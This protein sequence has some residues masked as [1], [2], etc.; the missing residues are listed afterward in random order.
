MVWDPLTILGVLAL[1][2]DRSKQ[3]GSMLSRGLKA[4]RSARGSQEC[5][6]AVLVDVVLCVW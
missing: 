5:D 1:L 4:V 6:C 2:L 3:E